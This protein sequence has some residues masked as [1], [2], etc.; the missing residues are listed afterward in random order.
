MGTEPGVVVHS[1][2]ILSD[3]GDLWVIYGAIG[4][5]EG[6]AGYRRLTV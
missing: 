2:W 1:N 3:S 6:I 5:K 4:K